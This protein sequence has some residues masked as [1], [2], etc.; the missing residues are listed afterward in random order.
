[1][2]HLSR[3]WSE[4]LNTGLV[5]SSSEIAERC[6]MTPGRVRQIV[7]LTQIDPRI[8]EFLLR[9]EGKRALR[10]FSES[11]IRPIVSLP[12]EEQFHKFEERFR[13]R[14]PR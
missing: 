12:H 10:G 5:D 14:L 8:A 3:N 2:I 7:R 13:L 4:A 11:R 1:M 9:L 6:G